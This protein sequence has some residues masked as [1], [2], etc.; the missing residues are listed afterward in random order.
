MFEKLCG[1][2]GSGQKFPVDLPLAVPSY[3]LRRIL[4]T[5]LAGHVYFMGIYRLKWECTMEVGGKKNNSP[6][7]EQKRKKNKCILISQMTQQI[8]HSSM[9]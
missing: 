9:M 4:F 5:L 6:N 7:T 2:F 3:P 1:N 8:A